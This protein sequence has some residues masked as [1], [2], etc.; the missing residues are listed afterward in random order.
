MR[1]LF[2]S[3]T[4]VWNI[5]HPKKN[6]ERVLSSIYTG[7]HV[8]SRQILIKLEYQRQISRNT[9]ITYFMNIRPVEAE[10]LHKDRETRTE[11]RRSW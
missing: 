11:T 5:S 4:L 8:K 3:T 1:V 2:F 9:K 10:S 6:W 7:L